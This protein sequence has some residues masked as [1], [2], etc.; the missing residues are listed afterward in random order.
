M[1]LV[2]VIMMIL[3]YVLF[4]Q[5]PSNCDAIILENKK[6]QEALKGKNDEINQIRN[7]A[8]R[9]PVIETKPEVPAV[10]RVPQKRR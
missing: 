6:M 7:R 4:I 9:Q 1:F 5:K 3:F 2:F 8:L 10:I